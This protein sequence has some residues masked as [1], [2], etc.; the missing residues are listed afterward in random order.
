MWKRKAA[1]GGGTWEGE[2]WSRVGGAG[3]WVVSGSFGGGREGEGEGSSGGAWRSGGGRAISTR[4][5]QDD[6]KLGRAKEAYLGTRL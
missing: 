1:G 2:N 4:G 5:E 6:K 3:E